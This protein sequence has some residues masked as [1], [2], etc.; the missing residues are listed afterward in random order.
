MPF[1]Y[2]M[3][4]VEWPDDDSEPPPPKP[5]QF[6]YLRPPEFGGARDPVRFEDP[7]RA[8]APSPSSRRIVD[9]LLGRSQP[10]TRD[11]WKEKAR[12]FVST[13]VLELRALGA[14]SV[15]CRYDGGNDEG[16]AWLDR[17]EMRD[18]ASIGCD[19][20]VARLRAAGIEDKLRSTGHI[21]GNAGFAG[22]DALTATI[23][24]M[25]AH[26]WATRLLGEG[27]GTGEYTMFGAFSVD[28]DTCTITDDPNA[29]PVVENIVIDLGRS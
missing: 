29:D 22:M 3:S 16:F 26:E 7:S 10:T 15:Y 19:E 24:W 4:D 18:G 25:L 1:I 6:Q 23:S 20:L 11:D 17:V 21:S 5:E 28:L 14:R 2:D 12:E 9:R 8:G 13:M 27:Y